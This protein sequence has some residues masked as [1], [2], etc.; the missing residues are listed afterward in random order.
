MQ[1]THSNSLTEPVDSSDDGFCAAV[2][3]VLFSS[4]G[5]SS[6]LSVV[7]FKA[8]FVDAYRPVLDDELF[9]EMAD[10]DGSSKRIKLEGEQDRRTPSV[11]GLAEL[12]RGTDVCLSL[13]YRVS[14][15]KDLNE[16]RIQIYRR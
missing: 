1:T 16:P 7:V 13:N 2:R 12:E 9:E 4:V 10:V 15:I 3:F 14:Q 6:T 11:R 8:E 5:L